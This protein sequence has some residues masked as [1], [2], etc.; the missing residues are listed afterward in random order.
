[1]DAV[2]VLDVGARDP[3]RGVLLEVLAEEHLPRRLGGAHAVHPAL[4]RGGAPGRLRHHH[5]CDAVVVVDH[6]ALGGAGGGI[7]DLVEIRQLQPATIDLH[8]LLSSGHGPTV[9][10]ITRSVTRPAG[11]RDPPRRPPRRPRAPSAGGRRAGTGAPRT[12]R[13]GSRSAPRGRGRS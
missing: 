7:E 9:P 11:P 2:A 4:A 5:L 12:A 10:S 1:R 8:L 3:V 13:R 6:L